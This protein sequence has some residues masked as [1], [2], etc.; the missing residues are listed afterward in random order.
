MSGLF[1]RIALAA[2]LGLLSAAA[3]A[4]GYVRE[5]SPLL[6]AVTA[7]HGGTVYLFGTVH[8]GNTALYPLPPAVESAFGRASRLA[9]EIDPTDEEVAK[10]ALQRMTYPARDALH[11]HVP[12]ETFMRVKQASQRLGLDVNAMDRMRPGLASLALSSA[13]LEKDGYERELGLDRYLAKRAQ[14]EGKQVVQLETAAQQA[15]LL[16]QLPAATQRAM[17]TG[18]L[19]RLRNR[20]L[21]NRTNELMDAWATGNVDWMTELSKGDG[22]AITAKKPDTFTRRLYTRCNTQM[23]KKI[24]GMLKD[25]QTTFVAVGTMHL[26]GESG[27]VRQLGKK[28][29]V[30]RRVDT[31]D[32]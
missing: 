13:Q 15:Q 24:G 6:Y 16:A 31:R 26:I 28:G 30:V 19:A 1:K 4:Q 11:R 27:L 3:C 25:S 8:V 14:R 23:A 22:V 17:L 5:R 2:A 32:L 29:Y 9:L 7:K 20:E 21:T 18:T 10:D 12:A